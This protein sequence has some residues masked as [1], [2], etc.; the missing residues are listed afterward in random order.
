LKRRTGLGLG[1]LGLALLGLGAAGCAGP[2]AAG[3][4]NALVS[5]APGAG[6]TERLRGLN[7]QLDTAISGVTDLYAPLPAR[8]G[9]L[10]TLPADVARADLDPDIVRAGLQDCFAAP[11]QGPCNAPGVTSLLDWST[12]MG[13]GIHGM[14]EDKVA[15]LSFLRTALAIIM[16]RSPALVHQLAESRVQVERIIAEGYD[17][18]E[19]TEI[20][21]LEAARNKDAARASFQRLMKEKE[22]FERLSAR[23]EAE[24]RPLSDRAL[25]L[26]QQV[27]ASLQRFGDAP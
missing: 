25:G 3:P 12:A 9:A 13:P 16:E 27:V 1:P 8:A 4:D 20:N 24:V 10:P 14:V 6:L 23:V 11:G 5:Q 21:P 15:Q 18:V 7:D 26:H 2:D 19:S 17:V 22:R